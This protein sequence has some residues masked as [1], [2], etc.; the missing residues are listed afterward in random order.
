MLLISA[1]SAHPHL[2]TTASD[3]SDRVVSTP[4]MATSSSFSVPASSAP[5]SSPKPVFNAPTCRSKNS[6]K[7]KLS[8][9]TASVPRTFGKSTTSLTLS[10]PSDGTLSPTARNTFCNAYDSPRRDATSSVLPSLSAQVQP[11]LLRC[12]SGGKENGQVPYKLPRG[13]RS[14]LRNSP[15]GNH[16]RWTGQVREPTSYDLAN[17]CSNHK[18]FFDTKK[19]VRYRAPIQEEIRNVKYVAKHSDLYL[20][21]ELDSSDVS[22]F[23]SPEVGS[24]EDSQSDSKRDQSDDSECGDEPMKPIG[25]TR[26][27]FLKVKPPQHMRPNLAQQL[28]AALSCDTQVNSPTLPIT[29]SKPNLAIDPR[30]KG[31]R[32]WRWTLGPVIDGHV[33]PISHSDDSNEDRDDVNEPATPVTPT[34]TAFA[35]DVPMSG[36]NDGQTFSDFDVSSVRPPALKRRQTRL[37]FRITGLTG[38]TRGGTSHHDNRNSYLA[39]QD[40]HSRFSVRGDDQDDK[41][42]LRPSPPG[43]IA[44]LQQLLL[45]TNPAPFTTR[46]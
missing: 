20:E 46:N 25:L 10:I 16:A 11:P 17:S 35:T 23:S 9:Q 43:P 26:E 18:L 36:W 13:A 2:Y 41:W 19:Q 12:S 24:D 21:P 1:H 30:R 22:A 45:V 32:K 6:R 44:S 33:L 28:R 15:L 5:A 37:Q 7:P 39:A 29:Q 14:I 34:W 3:H 38:T 31:S 8:L 42:T 27:S 40:H 4:G